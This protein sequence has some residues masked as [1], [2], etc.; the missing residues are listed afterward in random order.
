M[1]DKMKTYILMLSESMLLTHPRSGEPTNF[2]QSFANARMCAKC[3]ETMKGMCMGECVTG[4]RK[5][6]TIRGNY[7]YWYKVFEEIEA[8]DACLSVRQWIGKPYRSKQV[9]LAR[10][11]CKDGI[12][13]QKMEFKK[14]DNS[15][16]P[17]VYT[18]ESAVPVNE[19]VMAENDGLD[20]QDWRDWF[21]GVEE[22][23]AMPIIHFTKF[24][25]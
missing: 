9:E 17:Y 18:G 7:E 1:K 16:L 5:R 20:I 22:G 10:L 4:Y 2:R 14:V 3:Q 12:G 11:T 25:Y 19:S 6:H 23:E 13:L 21:R 8:G 15:M 24:R